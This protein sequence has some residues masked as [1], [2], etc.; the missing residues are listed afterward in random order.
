M[1]ATYAPAMGD[2]ITELLTSWKLT[3]AATELVSRLAAGG[4]DEALA[5]VME[6]FELE[7]SARG[8]RRVDRLRKASKLP[9]PRRSTRST[10]PVR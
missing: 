9:P 3:T 10:A 2:R 6:V 7:A 8:Q 4:H 1:T 5:L